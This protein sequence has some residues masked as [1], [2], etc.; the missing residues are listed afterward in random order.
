M[1]K[2]TLCFVFFLVYTTPLLAQIGDATQVTQTTVIEK[3]VGLGAVIAVVA[4]WSRNQSILWA[5][6]H[7]ILSWFYVLYFAIT[8]SSID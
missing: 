8:R 7:G 1:K 4:S 3:G 2:L 6:L 5:I